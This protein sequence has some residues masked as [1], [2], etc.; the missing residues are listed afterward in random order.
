M[1]VRVGKVGGG[2]FLLDQG[3]ELFSDPKGSGVDFMFMSSLAN[4]FNQCF[5]KTF[6]EKQLNLG[7]YKYELGGGGRGFFMHMRGG[8]QIFWKCEGGVVNFF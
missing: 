2:G 5:K 7:I 6:H 1:E 4:I 3:G 8:G